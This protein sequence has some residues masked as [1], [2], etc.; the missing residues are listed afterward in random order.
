MKQPQNACINLDKKCRYR[1]K[2][3]T[4]IASLGCNCVIE[5]FRCDSMCDAYANCLKNAPVNKD[6]K[7]F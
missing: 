5:Y 2:D 3:K 7:W 6:G 1:K 4:R